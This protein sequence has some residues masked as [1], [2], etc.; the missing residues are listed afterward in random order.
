MSKAKRILAVLCAVSML[1]GNVIIAE[2]VYAAET[3]AEQIPA[4]VIP[5]G[6][7]E[8]AGDDPIIKNYNTGRSG[9]SYSKEELE[10][11]IRI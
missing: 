2:P 7:P 5:E 8:P 1:F 11:Q 6:T 10:E 3:A 9:H 4:E